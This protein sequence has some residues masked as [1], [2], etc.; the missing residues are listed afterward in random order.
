V[1]GVIVVSGSLFAV[2][3]AAGDD[4]AAPEQDDRPF[5]V[6]H[7]FPAGYHGQV[8]ITVTARDDA[9]RS[10]T[11]RWG[12]REKRFVHESDEP[13]IYWFVK[14][15][16]QPGERN[17]PVT[18]TVDPGARVAFDVGTPPMGAQDESTGWDEVLEDEAAVAAP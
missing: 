6:T 18:V 11:I 16:P 7:E 12:A 15:T 17:V 14:P 10:V 5:E 2:F 9:L 4:E 1:L 13:E 3:H 8:S